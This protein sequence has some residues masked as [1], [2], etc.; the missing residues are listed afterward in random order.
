MSARS[1]RTW[2]A[3]ALQRPPAGLEAIEASHTRMYLFADTAPPPHAARRRG[4]GC[5]SR[6]DAQQRARSRGRISARRVHDRHRRFGIRQVESREPSPGRP[7]L[8][9]ASSTKSPRTRTSALE[10]VRRARR[11]AHRSRHGSREAARARGSEADRA[12]AALQPRNVHGPL[13]RGAQ[14]LRSN[15]GTRARHFDAGRFSFN[16][17]KGRVRRARAK[18]S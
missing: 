15:E 6:H 2:R 4:A 12:H 7:R 5:D 13:R 16:V 8:G 14:A 9:A 10:L 3:S 18:A 1:R 17:A 11:R